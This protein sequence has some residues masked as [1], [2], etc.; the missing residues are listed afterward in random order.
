[1]FDLSTVAH[2]ISPENMA[3]LQSSIELAGDGLKRVTEYFIF[4]KGAEAACNDM[5]TVKH[6]I[7]YTIDISQ[8]DYIRLLRTWGGSQE[9]YVFC[10]ERCNDISI[11]IGRTNPRA[12]SILRELPPRPFF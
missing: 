6:A 2:I 5:M 3:H 8:S 7:R 10:Q 12:V 9:L 1:M 4:H 11:E